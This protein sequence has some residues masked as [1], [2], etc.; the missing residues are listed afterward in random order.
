MPSKIFQ[1]PRVTVGQAPFNDVRVGYNMAAGCLNLLVDSRPQRQRT[2]CLLQGLNEDPMEVS[3]D[4]KSCR[5]GP[6]VVVDCLDEDQAQSLKCCITGEAAPVKTAAL[7]SPATP[8]PVPA[9][10]TPPNR[11]GKGVDFTPEKVS[12]QTVEAMASTPEKKRRVEA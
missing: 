8:E 3:L 4:G 9:P 5:V 10:C 11:G 6:S 2:M 12:R 7:A 1:V